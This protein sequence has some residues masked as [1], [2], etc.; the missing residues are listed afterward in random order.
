MAER[1]SL[2]VDG[3]V[4]NFGATQAL[5]G[6]TMDVRA[7]SVH[8]LL[9][10]NGS[11]K[12]TLIKVLAGYHVRDAG[13]ITIRDAELPHEFDAAV[14]H[15]AGVRF[16]HQDL[17]LVENLTVAENLALRGNFVRS[18]YGGISWA[19]QRRA[20]EASLARVGARCA[21]HQ[22]VAELG[23]VDKTLLTIARA[24]QDIDVAQGI[25]VLDEPTA[26]LPQSEVGRVLHLVRRLRDDGASIILV[27]HRLEEV[28][29]VADFVTVLQDGECIFADDIAATTPGDIRSAIAGS[30]PRALAEPYGRADRPALSG[31]VALRV[32]GLRGSTIR[33]LSLNVQAGEILA[34]TGTVGSGR[35]ELGRLVYGLQ[36]IVSGTVSIGDGPWME[37]MDPKHARRLGLGYTPQERTAGLAMGD[38]IA[39]NVALPSMGGMLGALGVSKRRIAQASRDVVRDMTIR[40]ADEQLR[41]GLLSGGNQQKV[42]IGKWV[43]LGCVALILDEPLQGIDVGAKADIM[44]ALREQVTQRGGAVLWIESDAEMIPQYADRVIILARGEIVGEL[45][46]AELNRKNLL[47]MLYADGS[48]AA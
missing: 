45:A 5:R 17:G 36:P 18:R 15:A 30:S 19:R 4:K 33:D 24:L 39:D 28:F 46:G 32:R 40:P 37:H 1:I 16:V 44:T 11:G 34:V 27:T 13:T 22:T 25:L 38:A 6:V 2:A 21:P 43:K 10:H 14:V 31:A 48:V 29:E 8:A 9:G 26:R 42:S 41:V 7:G 20:A 12:S 47:Y 3:L 23:P 35:S